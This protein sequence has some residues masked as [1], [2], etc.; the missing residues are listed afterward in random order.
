MNFSMIF[1]L[2]PE[3]LSHVVIPL[4]PSARPERCDKLKLIIEKSLEDFFSSN[5]NSINSP[6]LAESRGCDWK[7]SSGEGEWEKFNPT[8]QY[9][10]EKCDG[11]KCKDMIKNRFSSSLD[12][13]KPF[14]VDRKFLHPPLLL[15]PPHL[16]RND[17]LPT[18]SRLL[19]VYKW[20]DKAISR[21][22]ET[23]AA[24]KRLPQ[25]R[26]SILSSPILDILQERKK[27]SPCRTWFKFESIDSFSF[28]P[29]MLLLESRKRDCVL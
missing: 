10:S 9:E 26:N 29:Q 27:K 13:S 24:M 2:L 15:H 23:V 3:T 18:K 16:H 5:I 25:F 6:S 12:S 7:R 4:L 14:V 17:R 22:C 11:K 19:I 1:L 8:R 20:G 21:R 28:R